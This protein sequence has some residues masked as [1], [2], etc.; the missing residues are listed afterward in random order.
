MH[1]NCCPEQVLALQ[2]E[3]ETTSISFSKILEKNIISFFKEETASTVLA[4]QK[5]KQQ[6]LAFKKDKY[7]VLAF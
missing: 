5:K 6:A 4:F 3:T 7:Q 1:K 2:N